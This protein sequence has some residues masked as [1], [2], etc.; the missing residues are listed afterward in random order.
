MILQMR[1]LA[2]AQENTDDAELKN[3]TEKIINCWKGPPLSEDDII[4]K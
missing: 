3:D 4:G 1:H 2:A